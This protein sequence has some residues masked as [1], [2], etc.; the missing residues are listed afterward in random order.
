[1]SLQ[2][3]ISLQP[4]N[5]F[6]IDVRAKFFTEFHTEDDI[7][8]LR[9]EKEYT[10]YQKLVLG[11]GSNILFTKD[12]NGLVIHNAIKGIEATIQQSDTVLVKAAAGEV[13]HELVLWC[14][15]RGYAGIENLS[16]IPGLTGAA[17]IQNI[18]A[19]GVEIKDVFHA[20]TAIHLHTGESVTFDLNS[21]RFGYRDS[22]FKNQHKD[23][24]IITSVTLKLRNLKDPRTSYSYKVDYGDIKATLSE[25]NVHNL[26]LKAVS[27]AVC[28]IR[29]TK[30]PNPKELGNAGSFFK[31]PVIEQTQFEMLK[32][33]YP[34]I[35]GYSQPDGTVKVPAGWL[36]EQCGWKGKV[37]G[38][39][40]SHKRQALVLVN[41][42]NA[43]G[44]EVWQLAKDIQASVKDKFNIEISTEVNII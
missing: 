28:H 26:S 12:F 34:L 44:S 20:L 11:G 2:H 14:I 8:S 43:T 27:D 3:N 29:R 9:S 41:Y 32:Q 33:T 42:G 16:L 5:T 31:N 17:P 38:N 13:W 40:G 25:M 7:R 1:M 23:E 37:V 6:G 21:C 10:T 24:F 15:D 39:T 19:Y 36:I 22:V 18:G 4:F 35:P 30:L